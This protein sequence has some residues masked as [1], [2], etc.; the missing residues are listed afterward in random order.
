MLVM[1]E[2]EDQLRQGRVGMFHRLMLAGVWLLKRRGKGWSGLISWTLGLG[3][4]LG[5]MQVRV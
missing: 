1:Q 5:S 3:H 4:G 2:S